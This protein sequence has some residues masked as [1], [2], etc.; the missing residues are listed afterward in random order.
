MSEKMTPTDA[1]PLTAEELEFIKM[2]RQQVVHSAS[3]KVA[4]EDVGKLLCA[5][6]TLTRKNQKLAEQL[7]LT[8]HALDVEEINHAETEAK[9]QELQAQVGVLVGHC[10]KLYVDCTTTPQQT[11]HYCAICGSNRDD[12]LVSQPIEHAADCPFSNLPASAQAFL[13][14]KEAAEAEAKRLREQLD[15]LRR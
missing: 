6:D 15:A 2:V 11:Y 3:A 9:V 5:Y 14:E 4:F 13:A 7:S 8:K 10:T 1:S 12:V